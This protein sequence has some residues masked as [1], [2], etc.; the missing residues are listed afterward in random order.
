MKI[1]V[2]NEIHIVVKRIR[3]WLMYLPIREFVLYLFYVPER[4]AVLICWLFSGWMKSTYQLLDTDEGRSVTVDT[5]N[6]EVLLKVIKGWWYRFNLIVVAPYVAV[7][8]SS[9]EL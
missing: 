8:H 6:I 2:I 4:R 5:T 7:S 9:D 1:T 3:D